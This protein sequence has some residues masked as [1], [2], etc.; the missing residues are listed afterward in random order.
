MDFNGD[1]Y[2]AI[3]YCHF[4]GKV[5]RTRDFTSLTVSVYHPLLQK[6]VPLAVM[7]C[8]SED[9]MNIENLLERI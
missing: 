1:S 5:K 3:E 8:K 9:T 6:Q 2:L 7:E 4:D